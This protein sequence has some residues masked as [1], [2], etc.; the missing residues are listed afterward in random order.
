MAPVRISVQRDPAGMANPKINKRRLPTDPVTQHRLRFHTWH[1]PNKRLLCACMRP[2]CTLREPFV[3]AHSA[4]LPHPSD[5]HRAPLPDGRLGDR[6]RNYG[7]CLSSRRGAQLIRPQPFLCLYQV[8]FQAFKGQVRPQTGEGADWVVPTLPEIACVIAVEL[9]FL[10]FSFPQEIIF[11]LTLKTVDLYAV[12][13]FL[14]LFVQNP[15]Q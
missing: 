6:T 7:H 10:W 3:S 14:L 5:S 13:H 2:S 8:G 4:E 15:A 12:G 11:P 9:L 1:L